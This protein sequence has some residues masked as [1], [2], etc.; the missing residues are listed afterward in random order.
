MTERSTSEK[1]AAAARRLLDREGADA[2]TMRRVAEAVGITAMAVYRHYPNRAGLLNVLADEGFAELA[3]RLDGLG[4]AGDVKRRLERVMDIFL[5]H[6]LERPRLFELM[7]LKPREGA[8]RFPKDFRAGRSPTANPSAVILREGMEAG[9]LREDDVWEIVFEMGAL[10]QG[11]VML[12]LGGRTSMSEKEFRKFCR[13][14]FER[15]MHGICK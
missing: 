2:V 14:S 15:Y 11:L 4:L 10:L 3:V 5:D 6:A 8:R 12:Y 9:V 7:F 13:R 1:I